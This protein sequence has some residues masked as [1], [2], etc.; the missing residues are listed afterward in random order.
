M[1]SKLTDSMSFPQHT[2][3]PCRVAFPNWHA[4]IVSLWKDFDVAM[5][6]KLIHQSTSPSGIYRYA[7]DAAFEAHCELNDDR[8]ILGRP[9]RVHVLLLYVTMNSVMY[10]LAV[11]PNSPSPSLSSHCPSDQLHLVEPSL[12]CG[13]QVGNG[14]GVFSS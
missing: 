2:R 5:I 3:S 4:S 9:V 14:R 7:C 11:R 12:S 13:A 8:P 10:G 1:L 6:G